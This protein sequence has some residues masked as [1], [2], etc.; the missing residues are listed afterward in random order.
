MGTPKG[1][2]P[3]NKGL[4]KE[5]DERLLETSKNI[6]RSCQGRIP[7]N[8]NLTKVLDPRVKGRANSV[9]K[10]MTGHTHSTVS[11]IKIGVKRLNQSVSQ[12]TKHKLCLRS[13]A[14]WDN[15][16]KEERILRIGNM[17]HRRTPS[18]PEQVF[19]NLCKSFKYVGDG[20]LIIEGKNP[21]FVDATG[22]K[23]IEIWGEHWHKG[24]NP[25]DR[26]TLFKNLGY[27]CLIIRAK[28]LRHPEQVLVKVQSFVEAT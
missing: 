3:W 20:Q 25:Q 28:E 11:K 9:T 2:I 26:I 1:S 4:T 21:D 22:T 23:L 13:K 10:G 17:L 7:W 5:T 14:T 12:E 6:S 19:S 15:M 8:K 24:Q 27:A 18:Y 16:T